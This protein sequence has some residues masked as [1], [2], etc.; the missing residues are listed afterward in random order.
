MVLHGHFLQSSAWARVQERLG[1]RVVIDADRD[2]CWL[3]VVR[4]AGPFRYLYLPFGPSLRSPSALDAATQSAR[5][6]ARALGCAFVRFEPGP[7][8]VAAVAA[9]GARRVHTRQYENTLV[10]RLDVD[11]KTLRAGLA[12]G[13]RSGINAAA[14]RGLRIERT[15]DPSRM[16]EFVRLLR[17]TEQRAGFFSY[18]DPY[19]QAIAHELL[20]EGFACLYFT[21]AGERLAAG[22]LVFNFGPTSYYAFGATDAA[23]RALMPATPLVWQAIL[24]ARAEGRQ[25]FDFWGAAPPDAG[26]D[27]PWA[28]ITYFKRA[29]GGQPESYAGTWELTARALPARLFALAHALRR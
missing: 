12:G 13:H 14:K 17:E 29:F 20:P 26:P 19:F 18:E 28:G 5:A 25:R 6:R 24:D 3:G 23:S 1:N 9:T 21:W 10:L 7:I 27:H 2:W 22:A 15:A 4:R 11:E 16:E 8:D